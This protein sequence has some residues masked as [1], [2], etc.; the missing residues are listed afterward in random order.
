MSRNHIGYATPEELEE[1]RILNAQSDILY[2]SGRLSGDVEP[3]P[4]PEITPFV[5]CNKLE[6]EILGRMEVDPDE[7]ARIDLRTGSVFYAND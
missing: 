2:G 3:P 6:G 4:Y 5:E 1:L 7:D